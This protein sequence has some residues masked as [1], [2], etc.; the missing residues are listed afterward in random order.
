MN[1]TMR[2]NGQPQEHDVEPR[3]LLVHYLRD[4]ARSHRHQHRLRHLVLRGVHRADRRRVGQVL[5]HAG[6]PG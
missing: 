4:T 6:G 3:T 2:V 5:H 1:V